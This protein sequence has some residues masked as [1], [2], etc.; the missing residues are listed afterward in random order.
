[1]S[2]DEDTVYFTVSP[3]TTLTQDSGNFTIPITIDGKT[4]EKSFSWSCSKQGVSGKDGQDGKDGSDAI[5]ILL[6]NENHTFVANHL[7]STAE[8]IIYTDIIVYKG[9]TPIT[10]VIGTLPSVKGLTLSK[11]GVRITIK[12][13]YGLEL[14][15]NGSFNIPITVDGQVYNKTFSWT[16]VKDGNDGANG[17]DAKSV[18]ILASNMI[19]KS[20]DG[21]TTFTPNTITLTPKLQNLTYSNWQY[22]INGGSTWSGLSNSI[23]GWSVSNSVLTI[24]KSCS[25]FTKDI[26]S[27]V[28]RL[29]TTDSSFYDIITII[30]LHDV[31]D[32]DFEGIAED[33][34][35]EKV[36]ELDRRLNQQAV[37]N[38][39]TNNGESQGLFL[40]ENGDLY[41]NGEYIEAH[42]IKVEQLEVNGVTVLVK[43]I[44]DTTVD[45]V[46]I[47]T[48]NLL[49]KTSESFT[50]VGTN[51]TNQTSTMYYFVNKDNSP[52]IGHETVFSCKYTLSKGAKGSIHIQTNG[53]KTGGATEG[54]WYSLYRNYDV[55]TI[56]TT[57]EI[58][59]KTSFGDSDLN[60]FTGVSLRLDNFIGTITISECSMVVGNKATNWTPAPEDVQEDIGNIQEGITDIEQRLTNAELKVKDDSIISLVSK[61]FATKDELNDLSG[62]GENLIVNS[63]FDYG[64]EKWKGSTTQFE[65]IDDN[66]CSL[67]YT[68]TDLMEAKD[69]QIYTEPIVV[70]DL[71]GK[72]LTLTFDYKIIDKSI[73]TNTMIAYIRFF[74]ADHE[75]SSAQADAIAY[76]EVYY[77]S[78][79]IDNEKATS[80]TTVTVP[81]GAKYVRVGAYQAQNGDI[82]Y[83]KFQ[84]EVGNKATSWKANKEDTK[85]YTDEITKNISE[86]LKNLGDIFDLNNGIDSITPTTKVKLIME[87]NDTETL[88]NSLLVMCDSLGVEQFSLLIDTMSNNYNALGLAIE[89]IRA[90]ITETDEEGLG[91]I[92]A[93]F[94]TFYNSAEILNQAI[95]NNLQEETKYV[96]TQIEQL[97]ESIN[98]QISSFNDNF[99][100]I[101]TR[102]IFDE[103]GLTIKSSANATKY[104]KLDND[105]L[106]F[107]DNNTKVAE[108]TNQQLNI[109]KATI[110]SEMKIS[111]MKIKPSGSSGGGVIFV[112]E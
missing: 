55:T 27:V 35:Q 52:V 50:M 4:F 18:D 33:V 79:Y 68:Q 57:G 82:R 29:N 70:L 17:E 6:T 65:L 22:S 92:L 11:S 88:V 62:S 48:K 94:S 107:M 5:T 87:Y 14:A 39:L 81:T 56:E 89:T 103:D 36:D 1:M 59:T 45:G 66:D 10:P 42:T 93:K 72:E 53:Q 31:A 85:L 46:E 77:P 40:D 86:E 32:V 101:T 102:F 9:S 73:Q 100:Q 74:D 30:K 108:I 54:K 104:I 61:Q 37:F 21:G 63:D 47:G 44:V 112:F 7:G 25:L 110:T 58:S 43:D 41:I 13:N 105:S 111:N 12:A 2:Q 49:S 67:K 8:Q 84:L 26:T 83:S 96:S 19:F 34:A 71:V 24:N 106:D 15:D 78:D 16:K 75:D 20:T 64:F 69:Y 3:N 91:S 95:L 97:A 51:T 98:F 38:R 99:E 60:T 23:T 80:T 76:T 28:F 90:T 109:S